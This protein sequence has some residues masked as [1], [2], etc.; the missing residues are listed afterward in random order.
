MLK[1]IVFG[2]GQKVMPID[3]ET[4]RN[5]AD[6][7]NPNGKK[8]PKSHSEIFDEI[9]EML[10]IR[11]IPYEINDIYISEKGT[12][13]GTDKEV[14]KRN[15]KLLLFNPEATEADFVQKYDTE[16]TIINEVIGSITLLGD[17]QDKEMNL[18]IA[19]NQNDKGLTF[20]IGLRVWVCSNFT[21]LNVTDRFSNYGPDSLPYEV[22]ME[23]IEKKIDN[24]KTIWNEL[25]GLVK[26]M[27][28]IKVQLPEEKF[29]LLGELLTLATR[30]NAESAFKSPLNV[31]EVTK[32]AADTLEFKEGEVSLWTLFNTLTE[33]TS[34][35]NTL[36]NRIDQSVAVGDY[37]RNRYG[38][39]D[40]HVAIQQ[41][42][43]TVNEI[44]AK[45]SEY[46]LDS[47]EAFEAESMIDDIDPIKMAGEN[48]LETV[49]TDEILKKA[50]QDPEPETKEEEEN[51]S[52]V[53]T[54]TGEIFD[55]IKEI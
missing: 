15:E 20:G 21:M 47:D 55:E 54:N 3:I 17:L 6:Y 40:E 51:I 33:I 4:L 44:P 19:F 1:Q 36:S 37:F 22:I 10:D 35:S 43:D 52:N 30:A 42:R 53:D 16:L 45:I 23:M 28:S 50:K 9:T 39:I 32:L 26:A 24:L 2:D 49:S 11:K 25:S 14:K 38:L 48:P 7:R 29:A 8:F 27:M 18:V 41:D 46:P 5:S 34:S 12:V 31:T 13:P